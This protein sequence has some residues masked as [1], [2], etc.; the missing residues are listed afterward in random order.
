[1]EKRVGIYVVKSR[2]LRKKKQQK[3]SISSELRF[4]GRNILPKD[5]NAISNLYKKII[6]KRLKLFK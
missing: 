5:K 6:W 2:H 1:M 3:S 4:V